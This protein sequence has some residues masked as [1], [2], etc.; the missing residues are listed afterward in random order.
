MGY[1]RTHGARSV[2]EYKVRLTRLD[3]FDD[4]ERAL[5]TDYTVQVVAKSAIQA[6]WKGVRDAEANAEAAVGGRRYL[7]SWHATVEEA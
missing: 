3:W 6:E 7:W 4:P 5:P 2:T 1:E